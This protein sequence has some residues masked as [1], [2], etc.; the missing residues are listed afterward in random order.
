MTY[1]RTRLW[2][3]VTGVGSLVVLSSIALIYQLPGLI[4]SKSDFAWPSSGI[5]L[6]CVVAFLAMWLFPLDVLGGYLMPNR[7]KRS[8]QTFWQWFKGYW[9][10]V[11]LQTLVYVSTAF[12][13]LFAGQSGGLPAVVAV[14]VVATMVWAAIRDHRM[15]R[16]KID[17]PNVI[18]KLQDAV[19]L[20]QSWQIYVPRTIVVDHAD[21]GFTGG[22][23]GV[24]KHTTIVIPK[25]WTKKLSANELAVAI[26][27][28]ATAVNR[29]SYFYGLAFACTWNIIG[30]MLCTLLPGADVVTVAG[31][32][33]TACGFTLWSFLGLLIL[34]TVSRSASL[35]VDGVL[36][37]NGAATNIIENTAFEMDRLQDGEPHRSKII[38]AIFHPIPNVSSRGLAP[39]SNSV[40]AWN[41]ARMALLQSW[42]CFGFLSRSVHCN[43]GRPELW[44]MLPSD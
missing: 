17:T 7:F 22:I 15:L 14:M 20:I 36:R 43:V 19:V 12:L 27:R 30:F 9:A 23:M 11:V 37:E 1:A 21:E 8:E 38:E 39:P 10:G 13:I 2:L 18:S 28:R 31:L 35:Q 40:A 4:L 41:V 44:T 34:P 29:G 25:L 26:A 5:E 33:T 42:M 24:G 32:V 3:G 6:F 16:R